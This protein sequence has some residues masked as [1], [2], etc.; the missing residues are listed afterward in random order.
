MIGSILFHQSLESYP[1]FRIQTGE[2]NKFAILSDQT[3]TTSSFVAVLEIFDVG[4]KTPPNSHKHADEMFYVL[5][6][7]GVAMSGDHQVPLQQGDTF[8]VKAGYSHVVENTGSTRLYCLTLM[9]PDEDFAALIRA[10]V[11]DALDA[12]DLLILRPKVLGLP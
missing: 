10:G 5:H 8:L 9:V 12:E 4:G 3:S 1:V 6:G 7:R 2:S 11:P